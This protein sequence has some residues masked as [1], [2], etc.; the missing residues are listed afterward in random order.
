[1]ANVSQIT[2]KTNVYGAGSK[3]VIFP[4]RTNS[5]CLYNSVNASYINHAYCPYSHSCVNTNGPVNYNNYSQQCTRNAFGGDI[6]P[7]NNLTFESLGIKRP[8]LFQPNTY[9]LY[10]ESAP[11]LTQPPGQCQKRT[12]PCGGYSGYTCC[13]NLR[14]MA[15]PGWN[16]GFC[17]K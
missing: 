16:Y 10:P 3:G 15:Q 5:G 6:T 14:C 17:E 8:S 1:M 7:L 9:P 12:Q 2:S 13:K 11:I 4:T